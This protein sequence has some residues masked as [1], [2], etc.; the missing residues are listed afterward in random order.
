MVNSVSRAAAWSASLAPTRPKVAARWRSVIQTR[1]A[2]PWSGGGAPGGRSVA[3]EA[4]RG[5]V[6]EA[7]DQVAVDGLDVGVV[8]GRLGD[9]PQ[10]GAVGGGN[11]GQPPPGLAAPAPGGA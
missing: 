2:A 8:A 6:G 11:V 5:G 9:G 1:A 7:L 10:Q 3:A 4:G